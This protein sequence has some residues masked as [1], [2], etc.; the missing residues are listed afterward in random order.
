MKFLKP[1]ALSACVLAM[2]GCSV[3]QFSCNQTAAD[4]CLSIEDANSM[5][6]KGLYLTS[7]NH[8]GATMKA[9]REGKQSLARGKHTPNVWFAPGT[10]NTRGK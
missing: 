3:S 9:G 2:S 1:L 5:A 7:G 10:S 4:S 6:D 8:Y